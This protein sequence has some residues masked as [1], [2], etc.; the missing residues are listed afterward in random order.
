[1]LISN[2]AMQEITNKQHLLAEYYSEKDLVPSLCDLYVS[3]YTDCAV[4]VVFSS[5]DKNLIAYK[6]T[7]PV[8]AL[9]QIEPWLQ[10]DFNQI[11]S[12]SFTSDFFVTPSAFVANAYNTQKLSG[13]VMVDYNHTDSSKGT[14]YLNGLIQY[15][16]LKK[17]ANQLYLYRKGNQYTI[18]L[19]NFEQCLLA[20]SYTCDN[21]TEVLYFLLNALQISD[22][23]PS[24]ATLNIDYSILKQTE[25][26]K[27]LSP[28]FAKNISLSYAFEPSNPAVP[29][30]E[31]KLF[32][33]YAASLCA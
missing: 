16:L 15:H 6:I 3:H 12:V 25:M 21:E 10:S 29:D 7:N 4:L 28:H 26:V 33:C 30:L 24:D 19:M 2:I 18:L 14:H 20:N 31:Q 22:L 13:S 9:E 27:F 23:L 5:R 8:D 32:A 17:Q 11:I 1:M